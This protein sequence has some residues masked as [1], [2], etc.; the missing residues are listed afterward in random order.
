MFHLLIRKFCIDRIVNKI[1]KIPRPKKKTM[2]AYSGPIEWNLHFEK[3][4]VVHPKCF[5]DLEGENINLGPSDETDKEKTYKNPEYYSYHQMSFYD[6]LSDHSHLP[7]PDPFEEENKKK[8]YYE[9][10][11]LKCCVIHEEKQCEET[12]INFES[13]TSAAPQ[14][15]FEDEPDFSTIVYK[16]PSIPVSQPEEKFEPELNPNLV[17]TDDNHFVVKPSK[18]SS[19]K[20]HSKLII[21]K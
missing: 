1:V 17:M 18:S 3:P 11:N 21:K 7:Q 15:I 10:L 6:M 19:R 5:V 4:T 2:P 20:S 16:I 8:K 9:N 14:K 13:M 12:K